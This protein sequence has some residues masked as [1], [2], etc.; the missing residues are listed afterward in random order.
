MEINQKLKQTR[1]RIAFNRAGDLLWRIVPI[2]ALVSFISYTLAKQII[3]PHHRM[4]KLFVAIVLLMMILRF[5]MLY[6]LYVFMFLY[7]FPSG[8]SIGGTN[9]VF[10]TIIILVWFVRAHSEKI[11][12]FTGT[13]IDKLIALFIGSYIISLFNV[14]DPK[15]LKLSFDF[16]WT[17]T[18]AIAI[19]YLIVR[20]V[21][22][23]KKLTAL[24][25]VLAAGAIMVFITGAIEAFFP[26]TTII[27]GWI[28]LKGI[29]VSSL[30]RYGTYGG[31]IGGAIGEGILS[32][33]CAIM[34]FPIVYFFVRA[35][36]PI[37]KFLW[38]CSSLLAFFNMI[39]TANRGAFLSLTF[40][41]L[42]F[43]YLY[44]KRIP[45]V[46][47]VGIV[48]VF[49]GSLFAVEFILGKYT[50]IAS[51]TDR[52][53]NTTF[54]GGVPDTRQGVWEPALRKSFDHIFIGH[55]PVFE[56]GKGD[57]PDY[58]PHNAYIFYLYTVGLL[59]LSAFIAIAYKIIRM[60][61]LFKDKAV[62]GTPLSSL[63]S[64]FH[65]Q[66]V[67]FLILQ[68]RSDHQ[69]DHMYPYMIWI[70]FGLIVSAANLIRKRI[71]DESE[72]NETRSLHEVRE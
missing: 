1:I 63:M 20:L 51:V 52:F 29:G 19:F 9:Q 18:S 37:P 62:W 40:A 28:E 31:R 25:Q 64:I 5:Q 41:I 12:L 67:I 54:K 11:K 6:S 35:V 7:T 60:T 36:N 10:A 8:I 33:F 26:G 3:T 56:Y 47:M 71:D 16:I 59:G 32:D 55:G 49:I 14:D 68:L 42:Y 27:P 24:S 22:N 43:F 58:W 72:L 34:T 57:T 15:T 48:A 23:E 30:Y 4:I 17:Y 50:Y 66:F 46:K 13:E 39:G 53:T 38:G 65:V 70:I 44:R 21:D 69:R 2:T 45:M 61:L